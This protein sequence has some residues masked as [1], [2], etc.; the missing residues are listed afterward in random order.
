MFEPNPDID[1]DSNP[2]IVSTQGN[3]YT[4]GTYD[5]HTGMENYHILDGNNAI[6]GLRPVVTSSGQDTTDEDQPG[7]K[8]C[9]DRCAPLRD[10]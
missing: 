7:V 5:S 8:N 3:F 6:V 10:M 4:A 1:S 2:I 9:L